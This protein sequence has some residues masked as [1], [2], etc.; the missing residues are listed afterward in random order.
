MTGL[1]TAAAVTAAA[2]SPIKVGRGMIP[3]RTG[4]MSKAVVSW[5]AGGVAGGRFPEGYWIF[6]P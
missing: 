4:G 5:P 1:S 3:P 2:V 6:F